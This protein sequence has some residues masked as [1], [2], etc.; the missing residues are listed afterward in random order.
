MTE[1]LADP[2]QTAIPRRAP[3]DVVLDG[4]FR[5]VRPIGEGGMGVVWETV[6]VR[7]GEGRAIKFLRAESENEAAR[8]R[9]VR[10][11]EVL[12]GVSHPNLVATHAI[13]VDDDGTLA[14][15]MELLRGESLA[16]RLGR[17]RTLSLGQTCAILSRVAAAVRAAHAAGVVHRDLKPDNVFLCVDASGRTDVRVLDFGVAKKIEAVPDKLTD[18]GTLVGTP[19]YMSPEQASGERDLDGKTDVWAIGI[20]VFE[21]LTGQM[22]VV[23]QNYGQLLMQLV[24]GKLTKLASVRG[25]LPADFLA[26]VDAALAMRASRS[27]IG[28]FAAALVMRADPSIDAP[29]ASAPPSDPVAHTLDMRTA[30]R[31]PATPRSFAAPARPASRSRGPL[32]AG[33]FLLAAIGAGGIVASMRQRPAPEPATTASSVSAPPPVIVSAEVPAVASSSPPAATAPAS[34]P[35]SPSIKRP[36]PKPTGRAPQPPSSATGG[37]LQ[38]GV[39]GDV[40]F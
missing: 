15:V 30:S 25:D 23:A 34:A 24:Q 38:G 16:A 18:T 29:P 10:E 4:R 39:G 40:P 9:F 26:A 20:M 5:L 8:R 28:T 27:D 35:A 32:V 17:A 6:D 22:P 37:R 12:R 11:A 33:F 36:A 2:R 19:H 21:C 3:G 7:S 13:A 14:I 31:V 1:T